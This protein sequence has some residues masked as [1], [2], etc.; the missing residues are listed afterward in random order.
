MRKSWKWKKLFEKIVQSTPSSWYLLWKIFRG[1]TRISLIQKFLTELRMY[2]K[3]TK[4]KRTNRTDYF[5]ESVL[6]KFRW[7]IRTL[8][9]ASQDVNIRMWSIR[10]KFGSKRNLL[11]T[12][13]STIGWY[14]VYIFA[15]GQTRFGKTYIVERD[16]NS[17]EKKGIILR[18]LMKFW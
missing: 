10:W 4:R 14:N 13:Q 3:L 18:P 16:V 1:I 5:D 12:M 6:F 17:P 2:R 8:A 11:R 15:Y 9:S 7:E